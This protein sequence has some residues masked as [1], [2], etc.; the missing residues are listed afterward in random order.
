MELLLGKYLGLAA[1]LTLS[2]LGG[3]ALMAVLLWHQFGSAGL[4]QAAGFVLSSVLLGLVFL[5]LALFV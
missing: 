3:F 4:Y 5:S 2:T 1:A